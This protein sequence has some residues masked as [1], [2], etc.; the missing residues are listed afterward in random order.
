MSILL[1]NTKHIIVLMLLM[2]NK[3]VNK[4]Y[5]YVIKESLSRIK[6]NFIL[7]ILTVG[8]I[9]KFLMFALILYSHKP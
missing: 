8:F 4:Y 5:T 1:S 6:L 2:L 7:R 3:D 9:S